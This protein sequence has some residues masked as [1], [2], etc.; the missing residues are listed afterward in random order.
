LRVEADDGQLTQVLTNLVVNAIQATPV[1]GTVSLGARRVDQVP[2]PYVGGD[3][4]SWMAIDVRDTGTGVDDATRV[5]MFEPFYTTK[6]VGDGPASPVG[7]LGPRPR[8]WRLDRRAVDAGG[9][10]DV[11]GVLPSGPGGRSR[12]TKLFVVDDEREMVDLIAL[13]LKK[14]GSRSRRSRPAPT[15]S[16]RS[17]RAMST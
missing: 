1:H 5:R 14:R 3:E 2:P 15:P 8:A 17:R 11:H 12:V 7:Q 10:L 9:R 6:E 16:A 4:Q 13:G